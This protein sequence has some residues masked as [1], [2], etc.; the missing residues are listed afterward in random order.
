L[1][2]FKAIRGEAFPSDTILDA[3]DPKWPV[4]TVALDVP[5][6][7]AEGACS[8]TEL[9][10]Y[11]APPGHR[12][13]LDFAKQVTEKMHA[14]ACQ[15]VS[16][17]LNNGSTDGWN[18]IGSL[19]I[20]QGDYI[21]TEEQIYPSAQ[22]AFIPLGCKSAIVGVD[23]QGARADLLEQVLAQWD[24]SKGRRPH[25]FYI[26][27]VGQNPLGSTMGAERRRA[28]YAVCVKYGKSTSGW[29]EKSC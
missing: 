13:L 28:I 16:Y 27:P 3:E 14:P 9:L 7:S 19:V 15:N 26:V 24:D 8:M 5:T 10:Q 23:E 1:F 22:A 12:F 2:P 18:K 6:T 25:V 21:L 11:S 29:S 17:L 20:E 4:D